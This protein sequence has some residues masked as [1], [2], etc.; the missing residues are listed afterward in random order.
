M[1]PDLPQTVVTSRK[2]TANFTEE[3][4]VWA[5]FVSRWSIYQ[6]TFKNKAHSL[7]LI[8]IITEAM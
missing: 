4:I 5:K 8:T 6:F 7:H 3:N 2:Y 1:L